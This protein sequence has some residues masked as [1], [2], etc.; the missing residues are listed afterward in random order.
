MRERAEGVNATIAQS[1][2]RALVGRNAERRLIDDLLRSPRQGRGRALLLR[3]EAGIGKTAL[4]RYAIGRAKGMCILTAQG[5]PSE[6]EL[7]F[8]GLSEVL[9]P[10][11]DG[12]ERLPPPQ[13]AALA[14][15]L[16]IGPP[17]EAD[18]LGVSVATLNLL[19]LAAEAAP[20]LVAVD[21][22]H[23][24]DPASAEALLF[25]ARRLSGEPV[26]LLFAMREGEAAA[27]DLSGVPE[28]ALAGLDREAALELLSA[29]AENGLAPGVAERLVG[30]ARGNPLALIEIPT[31][32]SDDQR[33]GRTALDDPLPAGVGIARAFAR[34]LAALPAAARK[35]LLL[36]AASD[37]PRIDTFLYALGELGLEPAA[38][39]EAESAGLVTIDDLRISFRHPLLRSSAYSGAPAADRRAVH[40]AL[41]AA[42]GA[43]AAEDAVERRARH[44]AEA[45]L[46]RDEEVADLLAT[47]AARAAARHA[48]VVAAQTYERAARLSPEPEGE[49]ERLLA[50][51]G[52]WHVA[53]RSAEAAA[54]LESAERLASEPLLRMRIRHLRAR[55]DTWR[56]PA[57]DAYELLIADAEELRDRDPEEAASMAADAVLSAIVSGDIRG[58]VAAAERAYELA[59]PLGG[60]CGLRAALQLGKALILSGEGSRGRS[61]V[62]RCEELLEETS[63]LEHAD[64]LAQCAPALMTIE[65]F[66][67][68]DRVLSRTV[69]AARAANALGLLPYCLGALGELDLRLGRWTS[70]YANGLASV[71]L[72]R[73]SGQ[74]GQLS[75]NLARLARLEAAQGREGEC[76]EHAAEALALAET[77]GFGSTFPFARAALGLL[78]LGLGNP[79]A[80]IAHLEET[81]RW[82]D[83]VMGMYEPYRVEWMPD[84]VEAYVH[85]GRL[86]DAADLAGELERRAGRSIAS[87]PRAAAARCRGL[88]SGDSELEEHFESARE[89]HDRTPTPF[90]RARTELCYGTRLRRARRRTDARVSLRSAFEAFTQL[91]ARPWAGRSRS[92]LAAT[93]QTVRSREIRFSDELTPQELQVAWIVAEGATNKEAGAA[94]FLTPKTIEFHLAKIYRKL[95]VRSRTELARR[96]GSGEARAPAQSPA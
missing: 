53:N 92:E 22:L 34:R 88:V 7:P 72:A 58:A 20:V 64:E 25:A 36:A 70:A 60:L 14:G 41:A 24:L 28:L 90:E 95:G 81:R 74:Q 96:L 10:L 5:A 63:T 48:H 55:I 62:M 44:L 76:R 12:I 52:A 57:A 54:V 69:E 42:H 15:A 89:W 8:A 11:L 4:L 86:D 2:R 13:S 83:D 65:E 38:L 27:V 35:A 3:G 1:G 82:T 94:L 18:R 77:L 29:Q 32:L 40:R 23:W 19:S 85:S 6:S 50:A 67:A 51:A 21:D 79:A 93:G 68:T 17:V 37:T 87:W 66:A 9:R 56:G 84:L 91:G 30:T 59:E 47:A 73:E 16:A 71:D 43:S 26:A 80:A 31:L 75:Y 49:A 33:S 78:E 45:A 39:E 46:G 61:L